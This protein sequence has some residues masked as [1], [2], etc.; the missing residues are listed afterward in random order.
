MGGLDRGNRRPLLGGETEIR[1][2]QRVL[3]LLETPR[4]EYRRADA[5]L[6]EHPRQGKL[7]R[8]DAP[9]RCLLEKVP[10]DAEGLI[11]VVPIVVE[12][13]GLQACSL[14]KWFVLLVLAR[15]HS[16][17]QRVVAHDADPLLHAQ[18]KQLRLYG[19]VEGIIGRLKADEGLEAWARA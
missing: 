19:A 14:G 7:R 4:A 17:R 10:D 15:Q 11:R 13:E 16:P 9:P 6:A 2:L 12:R 18:R 3:D 1:P 8:A 5:R